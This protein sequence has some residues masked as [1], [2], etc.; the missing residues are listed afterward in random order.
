MLTVYT[1]FCDNNPI[2][3]DLT[4]IYVPEGMSII[5]A[6]GQEYS[7]E[8]VCCTDAKLI[9]EDC[10]SGTLTFSIMPTNVSYNTII[11]FTSTIVVREITYKNKK[12]QSSNI[13]Y[14]GRVVS[15]EEDITGKRTYTCE[16]ALAF[17]NDILQIGH[18]YNTST[19]S[20]VDGKFTTICQKEDLVGKYLDYLLNH[21]ETSDSNGQQGSSKD[22]PP[23]YAITCGDYYNLK[24][25]SSRKILLGNSD[26]VP[27]CVAYHE[28]DPD[29]GNV[30]EYWSLN[31]NPRVTEGILDRIFRTLVDKSGGHL[32]IRYEGETAY[33]DYLTNYNDPDLNRS[34]EYGKNI[35]SLKKTVSMAEHPATWIL[36]RG[37]SYTN[38][39]VVVTDNENYQTTNKSIDDTMY[40]AVD[41]STGFTG[42]ST[43]GVFYENISA[44][45]K[46]GRIDQIVDFPDTKGDKYNN[47]QE[48][49]T[50]SKEWFENQEIETQETEIEIVDTGRMAD[51]D[52]KPIHVLDQLHVVSGPNNI[53]DV[54]PVTKME[55]DLLQPFNTTFTLNK[56]NP[57]SLSS[58]IVNDQKKMH[59]SNIRQRANTDLIHKETANPIEELITKYSDGL[60]ENRLSELGLDEN[61]ENVINCRKY[62]DKYRYFNGFG[63]YASE[64]NGNANSL[65]NNFL[66]YSPASTMYND[67]IRYYSPLNNCSS[68]N[69]QY[70]NNAFTVFA[71]ASSTTENYY[72][73]QYKYP[74]Q[75]WITKSFLPSAMCT[76]LASLDN[77]CNIFYYN[78]FSGMYFF[79]KNNKNYVSISEYL[80][81]PGECGQMIGG[82][83]NDDHEFY[84]YP[85]VDNT[86]FTRKSKNDYDSYGR[87]Y[88]ALYK[89]SKSVD[90]NLELIDNPDFSI[91]VGSYKVENA[92]LPQISVSIIDNDHSYL[93]PGSVANGKSDGLTAKWQWGYGGIGTSITGGVY[94]TNIR[95]QFNIPKTAKTNFDKGLDYTTITGNTSSFMPIE[96]SICVGHVS[97][98]DKK[99]LKLKYSGEMNNRLLIF[100]GNPNTGIS[101]SFI[102]MRNELE[103]KYLE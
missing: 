83:G 34:I 62:Y 44:N 4:P 46:Y 88:I 80:Y 86:N 85:Y 59:N 41:G 69:E 75:A 20:Y 73:I 33:L 77:N 100:L 10:K 65:D 56:T 1:I 57:I 26:V 84:T 47:Q 42:Y 81:M 51:S 24:V 68:F 102:N 21:E 97:S 96:N 72:D 3:T 76:F 74:D 67:K 8:D 52:D 50:A 95:N 6:T 58:T 9:M 32:N 90:S 22:N 61:D 87:E 35:L 93:S 17:L 2:T 7:K 25:N 45:D 38:S 23:K 31:S 27:D 71:N 11:M 54:F 28:A 37:E 66:W 98:S 79:R 94:V 5:D 49:I 29:H 92:F 12:Q 60:I 48:L 36:A 40:S 43:K 15:Y 70:I 14:K 89:Y 55:I 101:Q 16:G 103:Y 99:P 82:K 63:M 91:K 13:I 78:H 53:D 30:P 19:L 18:G 39:N 64:Y